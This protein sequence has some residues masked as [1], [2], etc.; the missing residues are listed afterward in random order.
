MP[1]VTA[2]S[3]AVDRELLAWAAGFFDGEGS[4]IVY[5]R[6]DA[7]CPYPA[8][9]VVQATNDGEPA[10]VLRRFATAMDGLGGRI[11][12]SSRPP[13][14]HHKLK[15]SY[16][17]AGFVHTQAAVARLWPWL[18]QEKRLQAARTLSAY[19]RY[20]NS[21]YARTV[22]QGRRTH[23]PQGHAY[24]PENTYVS[25]SGRRHCRSCGKARWQKHNAVLKERRHAALREWATTDVRSQQDDD[26]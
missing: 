20:W 14:P 13:Q 26:T 16:R 5:R 18:G 11:F 23:C 2:A 3:N 6:S 19:L 15:H 25:P 4:T 7:G 9:T 10:D 24:V 8:L 17:I 22:N 1:H 12:K 21:E